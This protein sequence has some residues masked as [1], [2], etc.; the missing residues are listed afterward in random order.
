MPPFSLCL[1][2][3]MKL[4]VCPRVNRFTHG[5]AIRIKTEGVARVGKFR[6]HVRSMFGSIR[7][8][9]KRFYFLSDD[10]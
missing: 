5:F 2:R 10:V 3:D 4:I 7:N 8:W 6:Y 9:L 1:G